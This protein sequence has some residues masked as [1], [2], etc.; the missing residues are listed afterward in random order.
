M[1][2]P[3]GPGNPTSSPPPSLTRLCCKHTERDP[4]QREREAKGEEVLETVVE[5]KGSEGL[6]VLKAEPL[7]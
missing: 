7:A 4:P 1:S 2:G 6:L 3:F 5:K